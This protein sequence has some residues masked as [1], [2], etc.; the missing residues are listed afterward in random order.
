MI[1]IIEVL[2]VLLLAYG[3]LHEDELI[4]FETVMKQYIKKK[5]K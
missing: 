4:E 3:T 2:I 5:L 1:Y